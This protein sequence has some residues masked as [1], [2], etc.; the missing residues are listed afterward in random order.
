MN[1]EERRVSQDIVPILGVRQFSSHN[2]QTRTIC[3]QLLIN[4]SLFTVLIKQLGQVIL[5]QISH[6]ANVYSENCC[7]QPEI[8]FV[9]PLKGTDSLC[10]EASMC[11]FDDSD[12]SVR[13]QGPNTEAFFLWHES[14]LHTVTVTQTKT[15]TQ[16]QER[17]SQPQ[18]SSSFSL[19]WK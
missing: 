3:G 14:L 8:S 6:A 1:Y 17:D 5:L 18:C 9:F 4:I 11:H 10:R 16:T 7:S 15:G 19:L 13:H 12:V 2:T